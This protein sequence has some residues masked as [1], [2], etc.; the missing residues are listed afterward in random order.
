[1]ILARTPAPDPNLEAQQIV[2][3]SCFFFQFYLY[4]IHFELQ[5]F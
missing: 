1:M 2:Q 5:V 3:V 4:D